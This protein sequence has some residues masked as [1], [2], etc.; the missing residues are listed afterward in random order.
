MTV[1]NWEE[2]SKADG[3]ATE[4]LIDGNEFLSHKVL[5]IDANTTVNVSLLRELKDCY[6]SAIEMFR[7]SKVSYLPKQRFSNL[8]VFS[9]TEIPAKELI[10]LVGFLGHIPPSGRF[11]QCG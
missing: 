4:L 2:L 6:K 3:M 5:D 9:R 1:Y 7:F 10:N 8:G 11:R